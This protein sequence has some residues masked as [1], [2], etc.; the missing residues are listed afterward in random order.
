MELE[1]LLT[2]F[3]LSFVGVAVLSFFARRQI[4]D[5]PSVGDEEIIERNA[6]AYKVTSWLFLGSLLVPV[7]FY[8]FGVDENEAWP[9]ITGLLLS[10]ILP[11]AYLSVR[12]LRGGPDLDEF[13][14]YGELKDG[15]PRK[16]Q[17]SLF[18]CWL[19]I[20]AAAVIAARLMS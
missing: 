2:T 18:A 1:Q 12:K 14:R 8:F 4:E 3:L 16:W 9:A 19:V 11:V 15:W 5:H 13:L 20:V 6:T 7:S 10:I 17:I